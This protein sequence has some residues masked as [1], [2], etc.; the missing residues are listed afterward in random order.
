MRK[1][2][3]LI[4]L[5]SIGC[6]PNSL[7][8]YHQEGEAQVRKLVKELQG[9]H[10]REELQKA[11]PLLRRQFDLLVDLII[12]A[13][14]YEEKYPEEDFDATYKISYPPLLDEIK[15]MYLLEGGRDLME[16][17]EREPLLRLDD[18][19]RASLKRKERLK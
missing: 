18:F 3:W 14:R 8:E 13:R 10:S 5:V 11:L 6:S 4:L 2:L 17:A 7:E 19:E 1:I 12:E 16:K 15:R 9:I